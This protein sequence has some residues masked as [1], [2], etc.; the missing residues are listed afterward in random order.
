MNGVEIAKFLDDKLIIFT[1]AHNEYAA[2]AFDLDVIDYIRKPIQLERLQK[3]VTKALKHQSNL[4]LKNKFARLNTDKG[5]SIIY[6]DQICYIKSS[7]IDSRD[8]EALL[9]DGT[10]ISLKNISFEKL[11]SMLPQNIFCQINKREIISL[12]IV[13][14]FNFDQITT[15]LTDENNQPQILYLTEVYRKYFL[16]KV[17]I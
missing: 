1:T 8:K 13:K 6:F 4:K 14:H 5:K 9:H 17:E 2:E 12:D 7:N 11:L 16:E 10:K 3:A 15:T